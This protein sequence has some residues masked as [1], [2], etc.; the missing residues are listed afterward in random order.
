MIKKIINKIR[1][2]FFAQVISKNPKLQIIF[3]SVIMLALT[4]FLIFTFISYKT[5]KDSYNNETIGF[6]TKI[7]TYTE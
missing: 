3:N 6:L 2:N 1:K 4:I 5:L 7:L